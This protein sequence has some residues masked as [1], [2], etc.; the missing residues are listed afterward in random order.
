MKTIIKVL[1]LTLVIFSFSCKEEQSEDSKAFD[2]Q[3]KETV[4]IH[5]DVMPKMTELN[6]LIS[7]LEKEK[8]EIEASDNFEAEEVEKYEIAINDL[9]EAHDLMMSWMKNFSN[10]FSRTEINSGLATKDKDSIKA[11]QEMLSTQYNS[12][13]EMQEAITTAI[14]NAQLLLSE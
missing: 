1:F 4:Q 10:S 9:K 7:K 14:E 8:E 11:K 3:M 5:D 12:A 2:A 13:E 6:S